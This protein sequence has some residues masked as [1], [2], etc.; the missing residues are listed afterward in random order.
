MS[1]VRNRVGASR[2]GFTLLEIMLAVAVLGMVAVSIYRFV[3]T[4]LTATRVSTARFQEEADLEG[5][6]HFVRSQLSDL[7]VGL[8]A[9]VGEPHRF[10]NV[11]SDELRW[12]ARPGSGLLTRH[13]RGEYYVTLTMQE[14]E[15]GGGQELGL[16]RQETT[17]NEKPSWWPLLGGA[18]EFEVRYF[19]GRSREWVEKWTDV[20]V[21][22]TVVSVK[23]WIDGDTDPYET[24]VTVPYAAANVQMPNVNFGNGGGGG[25]GGRGGRGGGGGRGRRPQGQGQGQGGEGQPGG[26]RGGRGG[27]GGRGGS[28]PA[29]GG[30]SFQGGNRPGG[31]P[32][33][34]EG[35]GRPG[36]FQGQGTR[37]SGGAGAPQPG[38]GR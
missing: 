32:N 7:P 34:Q 11:S 12:L 37:P 1:L 8:G 26:G 22:P 10:N 27:Q 24:V 31:R 28:G 35:G 36:S 23:L 4:T 20:T 33:G 5:F 13:G 9:I 14:K 17:G 15:G 16:R 29:N 2:K 19:D 18:K 21:R 3:E 25:G 6:T 38:G 30:Q